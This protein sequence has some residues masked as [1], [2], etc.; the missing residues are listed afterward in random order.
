MIYK[1]ILTLYIVLLIFLL[2]NGY[3][4]IINIY[5]YNNI[6]LQY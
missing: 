6:T 5:Y 4:D 1:Y 3:I 2:V